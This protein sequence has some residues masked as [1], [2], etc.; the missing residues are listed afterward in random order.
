LPFTSLNDSSPIAVPSTVARPAL[1]E[2][3]V[4]DGLGRGSALVQLT[5]HVP[6][7]AFVG[8]V[9]LE[10]VEQ[11]PTMWPPSVVNATVVPSGAGLLYRSARRTVTGTTTPSI[12]NASTLGQLTAIENAFDAGS[13]VVTA[14][15]LDCVVKAGEAIEAVTRTEVCAVPELTTVWTVPSEPDWAVAGENEIP[16]TFVLNANVTTAPGRAAPVASTTLKMT[17][18]VSAKP[19]P[20]NPIVEGVADTNCIDPTEAEATVTVPLAVRPA[21]A[22]VAV[23]VITSAP[24]QPFAM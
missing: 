23:A 18:E 24:L 5:E 14:N 22:T 13:P 17:V 10:G 12:L 4:A 20:F 9:G 3:G 15:T 1:K 21:P 6:S 11:L 8:S 19:V 2:G 16:P 7:P